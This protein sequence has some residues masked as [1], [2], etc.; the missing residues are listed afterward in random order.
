MSDARPPAKRAGG[1]A[2]TDETVQRMLAVQE[3]KL[4]L[5][6]KQVEV[7]L[8]EIDHNQK[9]ADKSIQAQAEDRKDERA[10]Q[11][12]MHWQSLVFIF[13]CALMSFAFVAWALH[14]G[15]DVLVLDLVKVVLGFVGGWGA[16]NIRI[17]RRKEDEES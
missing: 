14:A 6:L 3:Q 9:I 16:A 11:R 13:G 4:S 7:S 8:R 15:K 2:L 12:T 5:E 10:S 17:R 1:A